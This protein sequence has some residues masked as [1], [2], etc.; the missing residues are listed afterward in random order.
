MRV[1]HTCCCRQRIGVGKF[2]S[3]DRTHLRIEMAIRSEGG[4]QIEL[5]DL[6]GVVWLRWVDGITQGM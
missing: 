6:I 1:E 2:G 5:S 4:F 3:T